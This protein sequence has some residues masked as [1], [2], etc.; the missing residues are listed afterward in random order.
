MKSTIEGVK[1]NTWTILYSSMLVTVWESQNY[2]DTYWVEPAYGPSK[3]FKGETAWMD[4]ER[5]AGDYE[6][7]AWGCTSVQEME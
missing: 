5:Y 6:S 4:A 7:K 3:T 2:E 1:P